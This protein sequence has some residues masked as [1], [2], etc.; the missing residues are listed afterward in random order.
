LPHAF[1]IWYRYDPAV[2]IIGATWHQND[3][4]FVQLLQHALSMSYYDGHRLVR[5]H[6]NDRNEVLNANRYCAWMFR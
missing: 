5:F 4:P 2:L 6:H 3:F 1:D